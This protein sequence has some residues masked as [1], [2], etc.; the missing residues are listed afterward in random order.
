MNRRPLILLAALALAGCGQ[1]GADT[2]RVKTAAGSPATID[3]A[4]RGSLGSIIVDAQ[5]RTLYLFA[6]D[7]GGKS[8]CSGAC[9]ES[10]PPL[11]AGGKPV[12]GAGLTGRLATVA[13][14]DGAPQITYDGHPLYRFAADQKPGDTN[15][16]GVNEFGGLWFTVSRSGT[17][18]T[19]SGTGSSGY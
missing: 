16:Q 15:G 17:A 12:A 13:R 14:S 9:E 11:R 18:A 10:W 8:A 6:R 5:D 7:T 3:I 19:G 2:P 1:A 4:D